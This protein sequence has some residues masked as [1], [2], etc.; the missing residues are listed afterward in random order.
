M[1]EKLYWHLADSL[2]GYVEPEYYEGILLTGLSLSYV[3]DNF[4]ETIPDEVKLHQLVKDPVNIQD[5]FIH[6][7]RIIEESIPFLAGVYQA[8]NIPWEQVDN[9]VIYEVLIK[10]HNVHP[11]TQDWDEIVQSIRDRTM[12]NV[13]GARGE[14]LTPNFFNKLMI[15]LLDI[16]EGTSFYDGTAG[17]AGNLCEVARQKRHLQKPVELYGQ[18]MNQK[19]WALGK[20]Y[21]L[22]TG[23]V[24]AKFVFRNTLTDPQF[25]ENQQVKQFDCIAMNIPFGLNLNDRIYDQLENDPYYRFSLGRLPKNNADM[26][27]ILHALSSLKAQGRA[28]IT[29][30]NGVLMRVGPDKNIRQNLIKTDQIE[31]IIS[32]PEKLF[33]ATAIPTNL[34]VL[35][36]NKPKEKKSKIQF[37]K[38]SNLYEEKRRERFLTEEHIERIYTSLLKGTVEKGFSILVPIVELK[39]NL[40]CSTYIQ[41]DEVAIEGHGKVKI[42]SNR[43][44]EGPYPVKETKKLGKLYRGLNVTSRTMEEVEEGP[45][46][47]IKLSD[48]Q[49]GQV[50]MEKLSSIEMKTN[51]KPELY[52][53]QAGDIIISSRG[54]T[55]KIAII[56]EHTGKILLS[57]NFIGVRPNNEVLSNYLQAYLESPIGQHLLR[58]K[59][60]G[61]AGSVL[62]PK[63]LEHV[64]IVVPPLEIQKHIAESYTNANQTYK[65]AIQ[66][67]E[68]DLKKSRQKIYE[69]M[70]I[71]SAFQILSK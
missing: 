36:K 11:S 45:Y 62:S 31:A 46:K 28:I 37:I 30:T 66:K 22:L 14:H 43:L 69:D 51:F 20:L 70:G 58:T 3:S 59:F 29:V 57:Q 47:L 18:E 50:L 35:N 55:I 6:S 9:K 63:N 10:I 12:K 26:A 42:N 13:G 32:L 54:T 7:L 71:V 21:L 5:N 8:L 41:E 15:T 49:D 53:V 23:C 60:T 19:V 68:A 39:D 16:K 2:R 25:L 61:T 17:A 56:P 4:E 40:L 65:K 64:E 1:F 34:L 24:D 52:L 44:K 27:F 67:A 33:P 38:A 48:V